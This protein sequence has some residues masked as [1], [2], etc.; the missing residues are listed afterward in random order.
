MKRTK[1]EYLNDM[2]EEAPIN[3]SHN[4]KPYVLELMELYA[5]N[6]YEHLIKLE[7]LINDEMNKSDDEINLSTIGQIVIDH[8]GY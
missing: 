1:E 6:K 8:L 7:K 4:L 3:F 5:N 2:I